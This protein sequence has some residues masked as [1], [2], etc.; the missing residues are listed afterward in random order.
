MH[1]D[2][3]VVLIQGLQRRG[4]QRNQVLILGLRPWRRDR[5]VTRERSGSEHSHRRSAGRADESVDNTVD[6]S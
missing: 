2:V 6:W 1:E 4:I 5:L 3:L